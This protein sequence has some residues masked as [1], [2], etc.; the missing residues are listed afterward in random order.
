M[1]ILP[2]ISFGRG[3]FLVYQGH[4][5]IFLAVPKIKVKSTLV[6]QPTQMP[7]LPYGRFD[8]LDTPEMTKET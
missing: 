7:N 4:I 2:P 5:N 6:F 8:L 1:V 3:Y